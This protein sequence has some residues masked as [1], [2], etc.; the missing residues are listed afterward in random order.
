MHTH[1]VMHTFDRVTACHPSAILAAGDA[2]A[3]VGS[4]SRVYISHCCINPS[5]LHMNQ[6]KPA[7][8]HAYNR[9]YSRI[10]GFEHSGCQV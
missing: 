1:V 9:Y 5:R 8:K 6:G 2:A 3:V 10:Y 7:T 4:W